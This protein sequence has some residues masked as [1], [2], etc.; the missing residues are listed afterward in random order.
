MFFSGP[1]I[2]EGWSKE[3]STFC[4][5]APASSYTINRNC[6]VIDLKKIHG[7]I[8]TKVIGLSNESN[9][10][11]IND[12]KYTSKNSYLTLSM[13]SRNTLQIK[14]YLS[15]MAERMFKIAIR[16]PALKTLDTVKDFLDKDNIKHNDVLIASYIPRGYKPQL[17]INSNKINSFVNITL[18]H[19]DNLYAETILNTVGLKYKGIGS[20]EAG[21]AS[22]M[23]IINSKLHL[24]TDNGL[25]MYDGSGLSHYDR[26]SPRFMVNFLS[27]AYNSS[28]GEKFYRDLPQSGISGTI[29]YRMS[30]KN[31]LGKVHAK[32]GTLKGVSSLSGY[33]MTAKNHR[34]TFSIILN[35]LK[36]NQRT[37]ARRFQDKVVAVFYKYL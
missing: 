25:I 26:V 2:P 3:D 21:I 30:N 20:T 12:S 33:V 16:N 28:I 31:L 34:I 4:Y 11:I 35:D 19:S 29:A 18:K 1:Y 10:N 37:N 32:T 22:V 9:I 13:N 27:K 14:G 23:N 6:L 17:S 24:N 7:S 8:K 15:R 5:G 36:D